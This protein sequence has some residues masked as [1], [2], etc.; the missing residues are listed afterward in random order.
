VFF[1]S[2][3]FKHEKVIRE[4]MIVLVFLLVCN[5]AFWM[6]F[7]QAGNSLN[8]FASN[9]VRQLT[10]PL[11]N[12]TMKFEEFQSVNAIF[13]VLLG[14]IFAAMWVKLDPKG[15]NP[16]IPRKFG[17]G[18]VQVAAGFALL[19]LAIKSA[20]PS[21]IVGWYALMALYFVHTMGELCLSPVGLS[22]VTKLAPERM[23]G[24]VMGGWFMSIAVGNYL[25][26]EFSSFAA[27]KVEAAA[28]L[29]DKAAAYGSAFTLLLLITAGIGVMLFLFSP[30]INKLMHGVK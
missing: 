29:G 16:S 25:A 22:M 7:E 10:I 28:T 1:L 5:V 17:L 4:R 19:V 21:G 3:A 12:W 30:M 2:I 15:L 27:K 13:I 14:P 11:F 23:T 8:F 6:A 9:H 26:G 18:L 20:G 24:M